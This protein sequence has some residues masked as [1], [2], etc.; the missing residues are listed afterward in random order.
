MLQ[1]LYK[2]KKVVWLKKKLLYSTYMRGGVKKQIEEFLW[3][4]VSLQPTTGR[5]VV[6]TSAEELPMLPHT[7]RRKWVKTLPQSNH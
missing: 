4:L 6:G 7:E 5:L 1:V 3:L 2:A